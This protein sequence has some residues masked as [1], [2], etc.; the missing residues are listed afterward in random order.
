VAQT[1]SE[2]S[3]ANDTIGSRSIPEIGSSVTCW[4]R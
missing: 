1:T 4:A 2:L 3:Y